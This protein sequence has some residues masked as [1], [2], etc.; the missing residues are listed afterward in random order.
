MTTAQLTLRVGETTGHREATFP[1][2]STLPSK[3]RGIPLP[4][5]IS[6]RLPYFRGATETAS[7]KAPALGP[8]M[9]GAQSVPY[10][11]VQLKNPNYQLVRPIVLRVQYSESGK[12]VASDSHVHMFGVGRS[13]N[14]AL[15]AYEVMLLDYF[16]D[17][18]QNCD[19][20]SDYLL[21]QLAWMSQVIERI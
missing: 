21:D 14:E 1:L 3:T 10:S 15:A 5:R 12:L 17:L 9:L 18:E 2:G 13:L 19:T 11:L 20:I 7:V 8:L 6:Y 16:D 4:I